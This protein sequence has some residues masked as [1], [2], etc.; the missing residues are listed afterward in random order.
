MSITSVFKSATL[1]LTAWYVLIIM[2]ISVIFSL[3]LYQGATRELDRASMRE[4][5]YFDDA[6]IFIP[7]NVNAFN[8]FRTQQIHSAKRNVARNLVT[9]N[10]VILLLG[11]GASYFLALKTLKPIEDALESQNRF[12]ADASHELRTPLASMKTELEVALRDQ[13]LALEESKKILKSNLEEVEKLEKLSTGLLKLA[14]NG[15]SMDPKSFQKVS[16]KKV[17]EEAQFKMKKPAET[18]N[19]T[20][21]STG[22]NAEIRGDEW[23]LTE[24]ISI[25]LDNAIKFSK[26]KSKVVITSG[27]EGKYGTIK[28]QDFG[29]GIEAKHIS[30]LFDRFYRAETSRAK[31]TEGG[32][33]LG[34][35][36]AK[37]IVDAHHGKIEV[38]SELGKGSIFT[39]RLPLIIQEKLQEESFPQD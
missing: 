21:E 17:I 23:S 15:N 18:K 26:E 29:A 14:Q 31:T 35:S 5:S 39:V 6:P 12:T 1:R 22:V 37:K 8:N 11:G 24:V 25:L 2:V 28:V 9:V 16:L 7:Y 33:G 3:V 19:I 36:I 4:T 34:L 13:N 20:L 32:Y 30:H 27:S 10:F 38:T